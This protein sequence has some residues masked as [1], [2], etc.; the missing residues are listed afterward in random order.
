MKAHQILTLLIISLVPAAVLVLN[1]ALPPYENNREV[2]NI[3]TNAPYVLFLL[4]A[5]FGLRLNQ[6]RIF[7]SAL[8]LATGY[9]SLKEPYFIL[10]FTTT[11]SLAAEVLSITV[12]LSLALLFISGEGKKLGKRGL[13]QLAI[14]ICPI[15]LMHFGMKYGNHIPEE[16]LKWS[17]MPTFEPFYL[18]QSSLIAAGAFLLAAIIPGDLSIR[19]FIWAIVFS[20]IPLFVNLNHLAG[21]SS[22][23]PWNLIH[24]SFSHLAISA[25]L[26]YCLYLLYWQKIYIDD[27]TGIHNRRAFNEALRSVGGKYSIAMA[28]IDHFKDFNDTYGH[29]AGDDVLRFV[30]QFLSTNSGAEVY[31]YGGEEFTI[32]F[33]RQYGEDLY[34][35]MESLCG[36][37]ANK[38]F[39]LRS[40]ASARKK[41][42]KKGRGKKKGESQTVNVTLSVGLAGSSSKLKSPKDVINAADNALYEAKETG[43][44]RVVT[45]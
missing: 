20:L 14:V 2:Y 15:G 25:L 41:S 44:N 27:L 23:S 11:K 19:A 29:A 4:V 43:R 35:F 30:A 32:I 36:E 38:A 16:I 42:S 7:F 8:L 39:H 28:D 24:T 6:S 34:R 1:P 12:P 18:P 21:S 10:Y 33:R 37:I 5:F 26:L 13:L 9:A 17:F 40:P 45:A 22:L 3:I 31:R